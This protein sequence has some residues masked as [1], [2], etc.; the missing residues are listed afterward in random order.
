MRQGF[1]LVELIVAIVLLAIGLGALAGTGT[2]IAREIAASGRTER[3]AMI[4]RSRLE[5]LRL[6][7]C[8]PGSGIID[9]GDLIEQWALSIASG[10]ATVVVSVAA[11]DGGRM[12]DQQ[13]RSAFAC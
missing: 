13:Y 2:W 4:A 8:T 1:T 9:H 10:R 5:L 7:P 11:R 3:A 12:H 6:A